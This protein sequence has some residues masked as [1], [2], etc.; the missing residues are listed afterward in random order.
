MLNMLV[1]DH[2][3]GRMEKFSAYPVQH[4]AVF[5]PEDVAVVLGLEQPEDPYGVPAHSV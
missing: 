4:S 2:E 5:P 1:E 3:E